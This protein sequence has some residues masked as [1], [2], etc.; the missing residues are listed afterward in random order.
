MSFALTQLPFPFTRTV[1]SNFSVLR[2]TESWILPLTLH[3]SLLSVQRVGTLRPTT[4]TSKR[5]DCSATPDVLS[6]PNYC[7]RI[8]IHSGSEKDPLCREDSP[9]S[10]GGIVDPKP[11]RQ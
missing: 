3:V 5:P 11:E 10:G 9:T 2:D 8:Q 4:G 6:V 7:W 1:S